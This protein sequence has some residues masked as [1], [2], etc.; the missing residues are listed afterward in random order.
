[1]FKAIGHPVL[2]LKR[3]QIGKLSLKGLKTG[4]WRFLNQNE[5]NYIRNL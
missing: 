1:M 3:T 2:K 4:V 5:I